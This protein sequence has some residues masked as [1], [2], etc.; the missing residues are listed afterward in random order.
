MIESL[1]SRLIKVKRRGKDS[2]VAVCPAHEDKSPSLA[3]RDVDG[4]ILL[5]CFAGCSVAE[6]LDS[7]GMTVSDLFAEPLTSSKPLRRP[8]PAADVLEAVAQDAFLVAVIASDLAA[9][10][11]ITEETRQTLTAAAGRL[12]AA[13]RIANA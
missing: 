3:I 7:L 12:D 5:H 11:P 9:G 10:S 13:R 1:L 2:W 8:F 4:K 6:I